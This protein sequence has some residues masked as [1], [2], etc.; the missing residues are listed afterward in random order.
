MGWG[1]SKSLHSQPQARKFKFKSPQ[2]QKSWVYWWVLSNLQ[3]R[4]SATDRLL[5]QNIKEMGIFPTTFYEAYITM[6]PKADTSKTYLRPICFKI[7]VNRMQQH[8]K[9]IHHDQAGFFFGKECF[10]IYK[11]VNIIHDVS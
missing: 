6:I 4:L 9:I 5:F 2:E 10:N 8:I 3:K 11:S 7:L 1:R